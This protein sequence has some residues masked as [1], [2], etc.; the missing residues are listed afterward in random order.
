M[1]HFQFSCQTPEQMRRNYVFISVKSLPECF[2]RLRP[3]I[4]PRLSSFGWCLLSLCL[5]A[6]AAAQTPR[7]K[8][9][10]A[11]QKLPH[12]ED[13]EEFQ[14]A[15][16][17]DCWNQGNTGVCWSYATSS[18]VESERARLGLPSARLSVMYP[19]YCQFLEKTRRFVQT[20]GA[21]RF[22]A[23]DLFTGV[24]ETC[25]EYG[26]LPASVF[27]TQTAAKLP[28]HTRLYAEL[29]ELIQSVK[30]SGQWDEEEAVS[31]AKA[32]LDRHLG[33]PPKTF[34]VN[35]KAFTPKSFC[36]EY[37]KLPW[38]DYVMLTSFEFAPFNTFT[39]FKV[40]DNW[41]HNTNYFN[42]P[43]PRFYDAFKSALRTGYSVVVSI[44]TTEP[45]YRITG[46]YCFVPESDLAGSGITQDLRELQFKNGSTTDDHAVHILGFR[47]FNG[48]DWFVAKDSWGTTWQK[49]N[50]G[51]LFIHSSYVKLKILAFMV[52]RDGVTPVLATL[53]RP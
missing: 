46:R 38:A 33:A 6:T 29:Q 51:S 14:T 21:S 24:A 36:N 49:G 37:A 47:E 26:L 17:L 16:H 31:K 44:D 25:Q 20:K 19:A 52:H 11:L 7:E 2:M 12:P 30:R 42:L 15:P 35:G 18:F 32:I 28:D 45:S 8:I 53:P 23:G 39:E 4:Y 40:P 22:D 50:Q 27:D 41:R 10:Q 48:E 1:Q 5:L 9:L 43:L 13:S 34:S 3:A